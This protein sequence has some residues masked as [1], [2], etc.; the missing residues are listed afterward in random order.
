MV[1]IIVIQRE[2]VEDDLPFGFGFRKAG[3]NE[4]VRVVEARDEEDRAKRNERDI[5]ACLRLV[6]DNVDEANHKEQRAARKQS[7]TNHDHFQ[8]NRETIHILIFDRGVDGALSLLGLLMV[9]RHL[10]ILLIHFLLF[11][12]RVMH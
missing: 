11:R 7:H 4:Q 2:F 10:L 6:V 5:S 9:N 8:R 1:S 3:T 12:L